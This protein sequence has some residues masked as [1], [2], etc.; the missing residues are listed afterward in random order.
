M[1]FAFLEDPILV[2]L[3]LPLDETCYRLQV[4]RLYLLKVATLSQEQGNQTNQPWGH[5][6]WEGHGNVHM[7]KLAVDG[8]KPPEIAPLYC[9]YAYTLGTSDTVSGIV[10]PPFFFWRE[11][12]SSSGF[13]PICTHV[14]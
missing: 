10:Q 14:F 9:T 5:Y 12:N 13:I 1:C 6:P 7:R 3:L 11:L 4:G 8:F 2:A